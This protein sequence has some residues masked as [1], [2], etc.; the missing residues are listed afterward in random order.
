MIEDASQWPEGLALQADLCVVGAG[1]AGIALAL[2]AAARG[3]QVTLLEAGR[4]P[5]DRFAQ[6]LYEGDVTG[7]DGQAL[8]CPPHRFRMRGLGGSSIRWGGRCMPLDPI[9]FEPRPWVP[10]SGWPITAQDLAPYYEAASEWAEAGCGGYDAPTALPDAPPMI[11]GLHSDIVL[12]RSLERFSCPTDFGRRYRR[13]LQVEARLRVLSGLVCTA[14]RLAPDG[15]SVKALALATSAGRRLQLRAKQVVLAV[16]G[17]ETA[18]LLLASN[19]VHRDGVG[20]RHGVVG[21]FY[22]CHLAANVGTL[23]LAGAPGNVR[24]GYEISPDGVY[25]RRR[26]TV[27]APHQRRLQ[28]LNAVAR[29]HFPSIADPSHRQGVL[30]GL[31]LARRCISYEYGRRLQDTSAP[32]PARWIRHAMNVVRDGPA[33]AS[34]LGHWLVRRSLAC[35][36]FPSVILAN[37]TNVFSLEVQLEQVPHPDSRITLADAVDALGQ[38]RVRVDWRWQPQDLDAASRWLDLVAS[39]IARSGVGRLQIDHRTLPQDLLRYGAYGGHHLGT[40]RMGRDPR[41][42]VVDAAGRVHGVENLFITGAAVFP[43]S[44]QANPTLTVL[45]L[46]VRLAHHLAPQADTALVADTAPAAA[47]AAGSLA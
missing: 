2:T 30:S 15:R 25:C 10:H 9:D 31:Y 27:A 44:G 19:D 17:I 33:T 43:T 45:A 6:S 3:R 41:T 8:H 40:A 21:R 18:R 34:F 7:P 11:A 39:E 26:L 16:G 42:S 24:H 32:T 28:L 5:L 47:R 20:N 13:R 35:R 22:M 23:T 36:K 14:L 12:T 46:A 29:L 38:P 1:P 4:Q 37:R